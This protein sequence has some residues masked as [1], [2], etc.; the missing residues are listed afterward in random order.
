LLNQPQ[1]V[2]AVITNGQAL[3]FGPTATPGS[4]TAT[5]T[6]AMTSTR[7]A[8]ALATRTN[9]PVLPTPTQPPPPTSTATAGGAAV[10]VGSASGAPNGQ[11]ML[12]VSLD[13]AD[14]SIAALV[15]DIGF[16]AHTPIDARPDGRPSCAVNPEINKGGTDFAFVPRDCAAGGTCTGVRAAVI[17]L[18]NTAAIANGSVL[19]TCTATIRR[20]AV[21]G[22]Y[23]RTCSSA[24]AADSL[25]HAVGLGCTSGAITVQA[26]CPGDCDGDHQVTVSEL[27][28][29]VNIL[30]GNLTLD[31]CGALDM[32]A[33]HELM[34]NELLAGVISLLNGCPPTS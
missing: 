7:T 28:T 6:T 22:T 26:A 13:A 33:D 18:D 19:F 2:D 14:V 34:I 12:A 30:L 8:T 10:I 11:V 24:Q 25:P 32:N 9:T 3:Q 23:P 4:P 20:G 1:L 16:D 17:A 31:Q 5:R 27:M 29:G 15:V 21:A